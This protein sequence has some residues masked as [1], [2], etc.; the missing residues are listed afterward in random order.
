MEAQSARRADLYV[1]TTGFSPVRIKQKERSLG[2]VSC[3]IEISKIPYMNQIQRYIAA[4]LIIFSSFVASADDAPHSIDMAN[5]LY[6][7]GKYAEAAEAYVAL[8]KVDGV[9]S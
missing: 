3:V 5:S 7:N 9:S 2:E 8:A 6:E 1:E 4:F